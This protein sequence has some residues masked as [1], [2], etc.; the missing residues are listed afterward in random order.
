MKKYEVKVYY[1]V[2]D[3]VVVESEES[4]DVISKASEISSD[5]SLNDMDVLD[6]DC[7]YIEL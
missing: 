2:V 4:W 3:T 7:H 6:I 1:T 5:R